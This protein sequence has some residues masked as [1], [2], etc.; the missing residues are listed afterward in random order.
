MGVISVSLPSDGTTAD[1]ADY[2]TPVTTIVNEINGN[3]DN[4]N[5]KTGAAIATAKLADDAGITAAKLGA[6][7]VTNA[8]LLLGEATAT[9]AT[10]ENTASTTYADLAT[11]TDTVTVTIGANLKA[12][13]FISAKLNNDTSA[14]ATFAGFAASGANTI[15][16]ADARSLNARLSAGAPD[17]QATWMYLATGLTAGSTTFKMKYRV[18]AGTGTISNRSIVVIPL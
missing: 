11:T 1:V 14:A 9:V 5:I 8:K 12:L 13:V 7:S 15:A 10:S 4:A 3:L 2:N 16:A 17:I 18:T 6:Q